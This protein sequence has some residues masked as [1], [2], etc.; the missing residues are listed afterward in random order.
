MGDRDTLGAPNEICPV[1]EDMKLIKKAGPKK[2]VAEAK[3]RPPQ[4]ILDAA[5][6][7]YRLHWAVIELRI[8]GKK[9]ELLDEGVIRE[10]HRAFNWLIG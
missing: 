6:Y 3:R 9:S 7:Y 2:F 4:E 10:R 5:D 1:S 8:K